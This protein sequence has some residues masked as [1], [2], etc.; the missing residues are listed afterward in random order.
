MKNLTN[1]QEGSVLQNLQNENIQEIKELCLKR[2][3][4]NQEDKDIEVYEITDYSL[5]L[6]HA[7]KMMEDGFS[8]QTLIFKKEKSKTLPET[9]KQPE[10]IP[11]LGV[12]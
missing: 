7:I 8:V 3:A 4:I 9:V 6:E 5:S 1:G 11:L 2:Q 12:I 10:E